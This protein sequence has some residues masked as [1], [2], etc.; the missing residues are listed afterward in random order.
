MLPSSLAWKLQRRLVVK[1]ML[2]CIR[3]DTT[4][5]KLYFLVQMCESSLLFLSSIKSVTEKSQQIVYANIWLFSS[6]SKRRTEWCCLL[7]LPHLWST[8]L[9]FPTL[10]TALRIVESNF[11]L[12]WPFQRFRIYRPLMIQL[13]MELIKLKDIAIS[14]HCQSKVWRSAQSF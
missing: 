8:L 6:I 12:I 1:E 14:C 3:W 7:L 9:V 2:Q 10:C 13:M 5:S 4:R 11:F